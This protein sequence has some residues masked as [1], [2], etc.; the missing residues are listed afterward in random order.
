[1]KTLPTHAYLWNLVYPIREEVVS[2]VVH[3]TYNSKTKVLALFSV[4][5]LSFSW[6]LYY[7]MANGEKL[8]FIQF[9]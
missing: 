9:F 2:V 4:E 8:L 1:M 6:W 3:P 5:F 7:F